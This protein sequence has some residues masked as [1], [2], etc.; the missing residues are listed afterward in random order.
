MTHG[1]PHADSTTDFEETAHPEGAVD[2]VAVAEAPAATGFEGPL[3]PDHGRAVWGETHDSSVRP[4]YGL[5]DR[6][7]GA[8][9]L[10]SLWDAVLR[11]HSTLSPLA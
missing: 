10:R 7:L 1:T 4:G 6:A 8:A 5:Y 11:H 9:Y 2:L 3:R